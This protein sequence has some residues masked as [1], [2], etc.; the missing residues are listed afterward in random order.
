MLFRDTIKKIGTAFTSRS[1][2]DDAEYMPRKSSVSKSAKPSKASKPAD[3][4]D[5]YAWASYF[6]NFEDQSDSDQDINLNKIVAKI[7]NYSPFMG[8]VLG[9]FKIIKSDDV[10]EI[11]STK[12]KIYYNPDALSEMD[13]DDQVELFIDALNNA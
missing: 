2:S 7:I 4:S 1:N 13:T 12:N 10:K 5:R 3:D 6:I 8:G 11:K 9:T